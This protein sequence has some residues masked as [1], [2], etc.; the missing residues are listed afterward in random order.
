MSKISSAGPSVNVT[1]TVGRVGIIAVYITLALG[2]RGV[3]L[4]GSHLSAANLLSFTILQI[5]YA[6]ALAWFFKA[7]RSWQ[8]SSLRLRFLLIALLTGL[9]LADGLLSASF[10]QFDWPV[11]MVLL[12][13]YCAILPVRASIALSLLLYLVMIVNF[14][15]AD[16]WNWL[17]A[18]SDWIGLLLL[19]GFVAFFLL[20]L[21]VLDAQ[22]RQAEELLHRIEQSNAEL[23]E[24]HQQLRRYA[25]EVEELT[26][27]RERTRLAREIHDALG[28]Y[29]SVLHMQLEAIS[30]WQERDPVRAAAEL[31]GAR[32]VATQALSE[33]HNAVAALRPSHVESLSLTGALAQLGS[34]FERAVSGT[35]LTLD[36][37]TPLP[38]LTSEMQIALY[39]V[40]Q[41][42][43]TNVR[44]HAHASKVLL[45]LRYEDEELELLVLDNGQGTASA[46]E[47]PSGG[48]GL[49]GLR[50]RLEA[51]G[52]CVSYGPAESQ[53]YRVAARLRVPLAVSPAVQQE[54]VEGG[55]Q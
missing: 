50:E 6:L 46:L 35:C 28:H 55:K 52:G 14:G 22:K 17:Q 27:M 15:V 20:L 53:G 23:A 38:P 2:Y 42:A 4:Q 29:L 40:A 33:V 21:R 8:I 10:L 13:V 9:A 54:Q 5:G 26:I 19:F 45:R 3:L 18:F 24:A 43:L 47:L 49:V 34:E 30:K 7:A 48:F 32:Q 36:L 51:L 44:K 1:R 12:T 31:A 41:E 16:Q 37:D 11:Y 39:R 25:E